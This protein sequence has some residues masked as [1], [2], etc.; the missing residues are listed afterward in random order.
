MVCFLSSRIKVQLHGY[1]EKL[2]TSFCVFR[3]YI[4]ASTVK[5]AAYLSK[6]LNKIPKR[7]VEK[8]REGNRVAKI[9]RFQL[10]ELHLLTKRSET[11]LG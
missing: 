3:K 5:G 11:G 2:P 9:V 10:F 1:A 8:A 7:K 4:P 6:R